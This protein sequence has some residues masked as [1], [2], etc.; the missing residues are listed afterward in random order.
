MTSFEQLAATSL[1][2]NWIY[3]LHGETESRLIRPDGATRDE[4]LE[5]LSR[6]FP[7]KVL[8]YL[9]PGGAS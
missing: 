9:K 4:V 1:H 3:R 2:V 7:G 5:S 8:Q 6:K